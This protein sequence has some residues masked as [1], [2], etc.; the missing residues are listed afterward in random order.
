MCEHT[1]FDGVCARLHMKTNGPEFMGMCVGARPGFLQ[2]HVRAYACRYR[3]RFVRVC[4][5]VR[6]R[7]S[8]CA[9]AIVKH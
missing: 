6:A 8:V 1:P 4:V 7:T 2:R 5:C 3:R 9:C